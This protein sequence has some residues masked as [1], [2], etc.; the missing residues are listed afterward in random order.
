MDSVQEHQVINALVG[1]DT[2]LYRNSPYFHMAVR[3]LAR[4]VLSMVES[5][6]EVAKEEEKRAEEFRPYLEKGIIP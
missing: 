5:A 3:T 6:K 1:R 4:G 2:A